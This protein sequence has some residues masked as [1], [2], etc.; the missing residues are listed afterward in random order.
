MSLENR[1]FLNPL[2]NAQAALGSFK[3]SLATIGGA[4]ATLGVSFAAFKSFEG[5]VG[6]FKEVFETGKELKAQ[7]DITGQTIKDLV[8]LKKAYS[9][10]GIDAGSVTT[11]L[12]MLQKSLGGVNEEGEPTKHIF[13]QLGLSIEGLK[14]KTAVEQIKA[15]GNAISGLADQESKQAAAAAI[16]GKFGGGNMLALA[17]NPNAIAEAAKLV[18]KQAEVYQRGAIIF[19]KVANAF[20]AV[21]TKVRGLF[22]GAAEFASP[23]ILSILNSLRSIDTV[24]IGRKVGESI[25][26]FVRVLQAAF[27]QGKLGEMA[28][29]SLKIGFGQAINFLSG[30]L[31]GA[32]SAIGGFLADVFSGAVK[33]LGNTDT[34]NG[35][36]TIL[37]GLGM[38]LSGAITKGIVGAL[39]GVSVF[40]KQLMPAENAKEYNAAADHQISAGTLGVGAGAGMMNDAA[41]A[42]GFSFVKAVTDAAANFK[43]SYK[44]GKVVDTAAMETKL[45]AIFKGLQD[46]L[47]PLQKALEDATQKG[48]GKLENV[49]ESKEAGKHL[50]HLRP[51]EGDR[52]SKIGLFVGSSGPANDY[53][54]RTANGVEK[55]VA[56]LAVLYPK[57]SPETAVAVWGQ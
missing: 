46:G 13:D 30:G 4:I 27:S 54:R 25:S 12:T 45:S 32:V 40:G 52:L 47:K 38:I 23:A 44:E 24:S 28:G 11:N 56:A 19:A 35:L 16:F 6:G 49:K 5:I 42:S 9:E 29:L 48:A 43:I 51:E 17:A 41:T 22:I 39:S 15:I 3:S 1:G 33:I 57:N 50:R 37:S 8:I 26:T 18:G 20:E 21:G 10:V 34:W 14:G 2:H 7:H 53:A 36:K 55:M 31:R